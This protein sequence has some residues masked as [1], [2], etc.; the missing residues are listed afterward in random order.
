MTCRLKIAIWFLDEEEIA[1]QSY[2]LRVCDFYLKKLQGSFYRR[3]ESKLVKLIICTPSSTPGD[4]LQHNTY[5]DKSADLLCAL[6]RSREH[7]PTTQR[8]RGV[9][10]VHITGC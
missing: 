2:L 10:L 8:E 5:S 7:L 9:K 3:T 1:W 4:P 6:S